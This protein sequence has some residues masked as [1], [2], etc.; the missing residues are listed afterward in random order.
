MSKYSAKQVSYVVFRRC[1]H[2]VTRFCAAASCASIAAAQSHRTSKRFR[3][4]PTWSDPHDASFTA[5]LLG[6]Q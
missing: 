3:R 1:E 4:S 2:K 5:C 6:A